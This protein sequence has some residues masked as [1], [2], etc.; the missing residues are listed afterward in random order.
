MYPGV[1]PVTATLTE[2][3]DAALQLAS[4]KLGVS[5]SAGGAVIAKLAVMVQPAK[6]VATTL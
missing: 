3:S 6:S 5:V 1:P 4:T 2:P